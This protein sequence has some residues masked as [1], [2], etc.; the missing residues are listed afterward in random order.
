MS[1]LQIRNFPDDLKERL[2]ERAGSVDLTMS[3][4]VIQLVSNDL[5]RPTMEEWL[6]RLEELPEHP[7]LNLTGARSVDEARAE[8]DDE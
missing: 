4:Y 3:D 1:T 6:V 5:A 8:L 2:R 7:E